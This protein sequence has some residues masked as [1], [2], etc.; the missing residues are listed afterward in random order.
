MKNTV[1]V[2]FIEFLVH[3]AGMMY[4]I[5]MY[6]MEQKRD[7][8]R[9]QAIETNLGFEVSQWFLWGVLSPEI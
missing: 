8:S 2:C 3:P 1:N 5:Y 9:L 7:I 4:K 6:Y